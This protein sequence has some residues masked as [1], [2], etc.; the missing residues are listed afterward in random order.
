MRGNAPVRIKT[1]SNGPGLA[2]TIE[3]SSVMR[4]LL[5]IT[6]S[7]RAPFSGT[8]VYIR[9]LSEELGRHDEVELVEVN[10]RR[11]RPPAG[12]GLGSVRNLFVDQRWTAATL[13][14]LAARTRADVIHHPL[15]A[16]ARRAG[17]VQVITVH[18]LAFERLPEQF[19]R[20]FR[21][22]A[23]KKHR[24]AALAAGAVI[25]VSETTAADVRELW[26][27][28]SERIVI[29][30]HGP[31]LR[32]ARPRTEPTHFLYVGDD[33]PR[34]NLATLLAAYGIYREGAVQPLELV[35]AGSAKAAGPGVR[36]EANVPDDRLAE[37][38]AG[39][40]ALVHPS[41]YEGFGLPVLE[42]MSA[43]T[44]VIAADIPALRELCG[45]AAR[46]ADPDDPVSFAAAMAEIGGQR[47]LAERGGHR[48]EQFSWADCARA[49][50]E[51]Y[52]LAC[53]SA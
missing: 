24:A 46:Y 5:D 2:G 38:Y 35:L 18:D 16:F 39:A 14:R 17:A 53:R 19:D 23:R 49:H 30:R 41:L 47:E 13:G 9:R 27:I 28:P 48:A 21:L 22:Y 12:G 26:G 10:N 6:Y 15:P 50:V 42:A 44:P 29:A 4:V 3:H 8:A 25:C 43:G 33:Q 36:V 51:A 52:S 7:S 37:L 31:G 45:D 20:A 32:A 11:R 1:K 34:K 40:S